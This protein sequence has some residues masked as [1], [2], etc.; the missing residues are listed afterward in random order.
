MA[1]NVGQDHRRQEPNGPQET[2]YSAFRAKKNTL[3]LTD[4]IEELWNQAN[5]FYAQLSKGGANGR[6]IKSHRPENDLAVRIQNIVA[7]ISFYAE[8]AGQPAVV[9]LRLIHGDFERKAIC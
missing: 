7:G 3:T 2:R 1:V 8:P 9:R 4:A 6:L 5:L